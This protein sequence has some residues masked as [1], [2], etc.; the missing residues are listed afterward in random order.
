MEIITV[1]QKAY[2]VI[3]LLGHGKGGN[4]ESYYYFDVCGN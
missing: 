3:R 1:N 2:N 4:L